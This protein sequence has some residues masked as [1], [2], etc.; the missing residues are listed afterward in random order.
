MLTDGQIRAGIM[1]K[2]SRHGR[3]GASHTPFENLK[4][5]FTLRDAGKQGS[6]KADR[7]GEELIRDGLILSK[8]AGCGLEASLNP[9]TG[10][11]TGTYLEMA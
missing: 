2:P 7:T 1:R 4:K 9:G 11:R 6:K 10:D 3:R 5:G 8:P